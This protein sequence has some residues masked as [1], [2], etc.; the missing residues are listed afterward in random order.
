VYCLKINYFFLWRCSSCADSSVLLVNLL[1]H[2]ITFDKIL[3]CTG[4]VCCVNSLYLKN[5]C[6]VASLSC[7]HK[8][9]GGGGVLGSYTIGILNHITDVS[10]KVV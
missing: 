8:L 2:F 3:Q 5:V 1:D 10:S 9:G 7:R 6:S 4:K